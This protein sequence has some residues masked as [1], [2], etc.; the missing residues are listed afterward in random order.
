MDK[1]PRGRETV[2]KD[3]SDNEGLDTAC[4]QIE[5]SIFD[6]A[7]QQGDIWSSTV[8]DYG[9]RK[10]R[11]ETASEKNHQGVSITLEAY[12]FGEL[13][14]PGELIWL[15]YPD[16]I[17][18]TTKGQNPS[19]K[20]HTHRQSKHDL[21]RLLVLSDK[22]PEDLKLIFQDLKNL[23]PE[24][25]TNS[26]DFEQL[27][28]ERLSALCNR[29]NNFIQARE[30]NTMYSVKQCSLPGKTGLLLSAR[31][32]NTND[33]NVVVQAT[34][35]STNGTVPYYKYVNDNG[36]GILRI[37]PGN[38]VAP[39]LASIEETLRIAELL[40]NAAEANKT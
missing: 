17:K 22:L 15:N 26:N 35:S 38:Q 29:V 3:R 4:R 30:H 2:L 36:S 27:D 23:L 37:Q 7:L 16:T 13:E 21:L 8:I 31:G 20:I 5:A 32:E 12:T 6:I 34:V 1:Y 10:L 40:K 25:T 33:N 18:G 19:L 9:E 24:N 14:V 11:V 39:R 28:T